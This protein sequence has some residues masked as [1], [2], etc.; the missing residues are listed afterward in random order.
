[1]NNY[2]EILPNLFLG[3]YKIASDKERLKALGIT[4]ILNCAKEI[5]CI[6]RGEF[7][8]SH[9]QLNDDPNTRVSHLFDEVHKYIDKVIGNNGKILVHCYA[10]IS[11]S[12]TIVISY[13]IHKKLFNSFPIIM[14]YVKNIRPNVNPNAGFTN[15]LKEFYKLKH[16]TVEKRNYDSVMIEFTD[17][18]REALIEE[19]ED[20]YLKN[21]EYLL[22]QSF[23][24]T[25][26][27]ESCKISP[28]D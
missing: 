12:A 9:I 17:T 8:Y 11:R 14:S 25:A 24:D 1:M 21:Y 15:Q 5:E 20:E 10:G 3:N 13:I 6:F 22:D 23:I 7:N 28:F 4:H 27:S 16:Y 26:Y 2:H 19:D 18:V